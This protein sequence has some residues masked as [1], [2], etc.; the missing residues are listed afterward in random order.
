MYLQVVGKHKNWENIS[1][2]RSFEHNKYIP[3]R[4]VADHLHVF[5]WRQVSS[6]NYSNGE[7]SWI[8]TIRQ[9]TTSCL[10]ADAVTVLQEYERSSVH[11]MDVSGGECERRGIRVRLGGN[12]FSISAMS[13]VRHR[14][15]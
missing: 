12:P 4:N 1:I 11:Y 2:W 3:K 15:S 13:I 14:Y 7:A 8:V 5:L 9:Y 6:R 10:A